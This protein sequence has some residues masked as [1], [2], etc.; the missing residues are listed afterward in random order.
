MLQKV[1]YKKKSIITI[2]L[3]FLIVNILK[4]VPM[5]EKNVKV[6]GYPVVADSKLLPH[7]ESILFANVGEFVIKP[8]VSADD[9][10]EAEYYLKA[11]LVSH[12]S[13]VALCYSGVV[14]YLRKNY[15]S[16]I[17]KLILVSSIYSE[18]ANYL[19]LLGEIQ[20]MVKEYQRAREYLSKAIKINALNPQAHLY[21]AIALEK[22]NNLEDALEH[23]RIS[24]ELNPA[25]SMAKK[26]IEKIIKLQKPLIEEN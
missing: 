2:F 5:E 9:L 21:L 8:Y 19:F 25:I 22:E 6:F 17:N 26:R 20:V 15:N 18:K 7:V 14:D 24:I 13:D 16:S 1:Y 3:F 12:K 4:C 23:Y 11:F 10:E